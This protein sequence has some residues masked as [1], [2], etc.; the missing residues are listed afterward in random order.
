[1]TRTTSTRKAATAFPVRF[2]KRMAITIPTSS[3]SVM[4]SYASVMFQD[5]M[6]WALLLLAIVLV[7]W[8]I[9]SIVGWFQKKQ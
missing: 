8:C 6:P 1:M 2:P 5:V 4:M 7:F 9:E 3:V